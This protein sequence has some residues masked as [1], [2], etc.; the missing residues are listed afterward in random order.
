MS[1]AIEQLIADLTERAKTGLGFADNM[2]LRALDFSETREKL[3]AVL[4]R[5]YSLIGAEPLPSGIEKLSQVLFR[6]NPP[7]GSATF[8]ALGMVIMFERS[9]N[10]FISA[11][12]VISVGKTQGFGAVPFAM[13]APSFVRATVRPS[14]D[15]ANMRMQERREGFWRGAGPGAHQAGARSTGTSH[16]SWETYTYGSSESYDTNGSKDW[17]TVDDEGRRWIIDEIT[18]DDQEAGVSRMAGLQMP[19]RDPATGT[20]V[21]CWEDYTYGCSES[22]DTDGQKDWHTVQDHGQR[23]VYDDIATD[24]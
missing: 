16:G 1:T 21:G 14:S 2:V 3:Q 6:L 17:H 8:D 4:D 9:S 20:S 10:K 5:N 13:N 15:P 11:T 7:P 18:N 24:D 19:Q 12:D 23:W 22:Y